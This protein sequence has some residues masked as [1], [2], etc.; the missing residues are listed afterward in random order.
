MSHNGKNGSLTVGIVFCVRKGILAWGTL[1]KLEISMRKSTSGAIEPS[2][3][4]GAVLAEGK[5]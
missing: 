3:S 5:Q 2:D 4:R 1:I